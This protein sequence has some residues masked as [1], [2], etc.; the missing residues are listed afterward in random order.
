MM[1]SRRPTAEQQDQPGAGTNDHKAIGAC[2]SPDNHR[3]HR[4][5]EA[6]FDEA[7]PSRS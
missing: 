7:T 6:E 1:A 2:V 5:R 3:E 4:Q